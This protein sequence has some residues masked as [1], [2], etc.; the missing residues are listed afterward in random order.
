MLC[1]IKMVSLFKGKQ[2][3]LDFKEREIISRE[4]KA[5]LVYQSNFIMMSRG[6]AMMT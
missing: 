5:I 6:D 1:V 2:A 3:K 4:R